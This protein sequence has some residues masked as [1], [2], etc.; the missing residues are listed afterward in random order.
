MIFSFLLGRVENEKL[1]FDEEKQWKVKVLLICK[2][3]AKSVAHVM[4]FVYV[5]MFSL[6]RHSF[7]F[8]GFCPLSVCRCSVV[9]LRIDYSSILS[10]FFHD[11][12][13]FKNFK[14]YVK[15][16]MTEYFKGETSMN[17]HWK[18]PSI[19]SKYGKIVLI[20]FAVQLTFCHSE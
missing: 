11:V 15:F 16:K 10:R 18:E 7:L 2:N 12:C 8:L 6:F 17:K 5:S 14:L 20:L 19:L 4:D 1:L 9:G 13:N 3:V